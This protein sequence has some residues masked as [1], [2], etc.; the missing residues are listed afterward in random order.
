MLVTGRLGRIGW[1]NPVMDL[2]VRAAE[3]VPYCLSFLLFYFRGYF[4]STR[5]LVGITPL[6]LIT[7]EASTGVKGSIVTVGNYSLT[8]RRFPS[9]KNII[10]ILTPPSIFPIERIWVLSPL[11]AVSVCPFPAP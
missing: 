7:S 6:I 10:S 4:T 11:P 2:I 3:I 9:T 5:S 1:H 8:G